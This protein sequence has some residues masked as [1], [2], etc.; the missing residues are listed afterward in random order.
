MNQTKSKRLQQIV[1]ALLILVVIGLA[2]WLSTHYKFEL[3]WTYG[4]RNTLTDA[5]RKM[6]K[7]MPDP[8]RLM[9]FDYENSQGR[10]EIEARANR[11]HR[12]KPDF[13]LEY[14]DPSVDPVK[15]REYNVSR[16]GEAVLEY[17]GRHETLQ[18]LTEP[19]ITGALQRLSDGAEHYI[20]FLEGHGERGFKAQVGQTQNDLTIFGDALTAKGLKLLPLNLLNS[21]KVPENASALVIASPTQTM[22]PH[23]VKLITDYVEAGGNLLWL[24]DPESPEGPAEL[25]ALLGITWQKGTVIFADYAKIGS[26]SPLVFFTSKY[27]PNAV[28]QSFKDITAFPLAHSIGYEK[29]VGKTR[30]WTPVPIIQTDER[31]WLETGKLDSTLAFDEKSG[32]IPGP[33][34]IGLTLTRERKNEDG[35]N[36]TQ[37]IALIGDSDFLADANIKALGNK[38]LGLN[39]V[40]WLASRDTQ[41]NIDVPKA[42][43]LVLRLPGWAYSTIGLGYTIVL[44]LLL[45]LFGVTRW[46][47]RRRK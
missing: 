40:Q 7:A 23:E 45:L 11:Y 32:D 30:G 35:K 4:N 15:V 10:S 34:T 46:I 25:S 42:P 9:I 8:V 14:V 31:S 38:Q 3:D 6:L 24:T 28:T 5:S 44:P 12:F 36:Y 22:L 17:Q 39:I 26:P 37:R 43:D 20:L 41:L 33:L 47:L 1:N 18:E 16:N 21:P 2:G 19:Q 29:E 27:P 13:T